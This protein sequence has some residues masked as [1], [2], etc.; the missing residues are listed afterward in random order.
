MEFL[1]KQYYRVTFKKLIRNPLNKVKN[2]KTLG[3][4]GDTGWNCSSI[5]TNQ[6]DG[7]V[8]SFIEKEGQYYNFI[9][10]I[11]N[12]WDSASQTGKLNTNLAAFSCCCKN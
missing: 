5:I 4:E 2:F 12:T 9:S 8:P 1:Q 7:K 3:Y 6:Q 10:G 11:A